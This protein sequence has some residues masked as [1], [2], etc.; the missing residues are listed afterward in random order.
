M[1]TITNKT[2][3]ISNRV[4]QTIHK[5]VLISMLHSTIVLPA[6]TLVYALN[7]GNNIINQVYSL[8]SKIE[9]DSESN[10]DSDK[11]ENSIVNKEYSK[12]NK[13]NVHYF[14]ADI[15]SGVIG[16]S[17]QISFDSPKDNFFTIS[18]DAQTLKSAKQ[19]VL[20]YEVYGLDGVSTIAKSI[21]NHPVTGGNIV[22][23][24]SSW[25]KKEK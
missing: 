8:P 4:W 9:L 5:I 24:N 13:I 23:W 17:N 1:N 25:S 12:S 16:Y 3:G 11:H 20:E 6:Q 2:Y 10:L 19:Y 22:K 21:N 15:K 7:N 18:I 14:S